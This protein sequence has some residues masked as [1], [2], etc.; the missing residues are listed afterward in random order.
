[1]F[2]RSLMLILLSSILL[3]QNYR[4]PIRASQSLSATFAEPRSRHLHAGIDIKTWGEMEVPCLAVADGYIE[5]IAVGYNGYGRG[6]WLRLKDGNV[7]L[8]GHLE[9]FTPHLEALIRN[10]Q[11]AEQK[12]SLRFAFEPEEFPVKAGS[13]IGYS[14]T[15][16]TEHPH[17]HF[18]IR[19]SLGN[20]QNPQRF[21]PEIQDEKPPVFDQLMLAPHG[22]DSRING[23]HFPVTFNMHEPVKRVSTT[24][25]FTVSVN[26]HDRAN[27]TYNKYNVYEVQLVVNDSLHF[28][29]V[30]DDVSHHLADELEL[31]YPGIKGRRGWKFM[32]LYNLDVNHAAPFVAGGMDGIIEPSGLSDLRVNLADIQGNQISKRLIFHEQVLAQWRLSIEGTSYTITRTFPEGGYENIQFYTGDNTHIPISETLY[33]L[34]STAWVLGSKDISSGVRALGSAGGQIKWIIPPAEQG[35]PE[36]KHRWAQKDDGYVLTLTTL[37]PYVFPLAYSLSADQTLKTGELTQVSETTCESDVISLEV[38][39]LAETVTLQLD[40]IALTSH[41]LTPM[42]PIPAGHQAIVPFELPKGQLTIDNSGTST[43]FIAADTISE[44]FDGQLVHGVSLQVL[45]SDDTQI[46]GILRFD[47]PEQEA[48][49]GIYIPGKKGVWRRF[50]PTLTEDPYEVRL[51]SGGQFYLLKDTTAPAIT[52]LQAYASVTRGDRM[53]FKVT[54]ATQVL[55]YAENGITARLD[56]TLFFPDYNPLR[57]ELSFHVPRRMGGGQHLFECSLRDGSGNEVQ[58]KH[59][60]RVKP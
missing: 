48:G 17:L 31:V 43:L 39:A 46:S 13:V 41:A 21:Y 15:S 56:G 9:Q 4:W 1:M 54:E 30:F 32:S 10:Q 44:H 59:R 36:L 47:E 18:E 38:R 8:Y 29:R 7:A 40:S 37:D 14:G 22:R 2:S 53:V 57:N 5:H 34:T 60:F 26:A 52:P 12:Y 55:D 28:E 45:Q 35:N 11:Q 24:G 19:D 23:S 49:W 20:L 25:P 3:G 42:R 6:L 33:T 27:G 58:F 50:N 51:T 16:G